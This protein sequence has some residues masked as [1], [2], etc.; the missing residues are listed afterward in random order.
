M[1][2]HYFEASFY[3]IVTETELHSCKYMQR[4]RGVKG[5]YFGLEVSWKESYNETII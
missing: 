4:N 3:Y 2:C 1:S 5:N